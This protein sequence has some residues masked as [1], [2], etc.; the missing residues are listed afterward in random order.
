MPS[1]KTQRQDA[2][3]GK[4]N[5][6]T[7]KQ[8]KEK[9]KKA[10]QLNYWKCVL[11]GL[12]FAIIVGGASGAGGAASGGSSTF[13]SLMYNN[14]HRE[15]TETVEEV[16]VEGIDENSD[17]VTV[18]VV[19]SDDNGN[20]IDVNETDVAFGIAVFSIVALTVFAIVLVASAV[21]IAV[22]VLLINPVEFGCRNFFRRNL[23]EPA[24]LS[25]LTFAFDKNYKNAV[26][27]AFFKDLFI[28]LW[29]LLFVIPGIIKAYEYRLVPYIFAENPDMKYSDILAESSKLMKG[30]KWKTFV[31]DLSFIGWELLSLCT[32]GLLSVFYVDPYKLQTDAALYEALKYGDKKEI[33]TV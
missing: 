29:S 2:A 21:G 24:K 10:F 13:S 15:E 28:W 23:D 27:T 17:P 31:L 11:C 19:T 25:S 33:A 6:W 18:T 8:I 9:A 4:R 14:Q 22:D 32:C 3:G 12:I 16:E 1:N 26:K 30:N 7:R 20:E 5:M